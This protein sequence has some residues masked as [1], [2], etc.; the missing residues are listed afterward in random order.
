MA[1][2]DDKVAIIT[3]SAQG[4]GRQIALALARS[5]ADIVI[6]DLTK[7]RGEPV[8][9]EIDQIGAQV[10]TLGCDVTNE[11]H[12]ANLVKDSFNYFGHIDIL[13]NNAGWQYVNTIE[14]STLDQWKKTMAV[15]LRGP[16]LCCREV[17]PI[18]RKQGKGVIIN[19]TSRA[20]R[21]PKANATAYGASKFGLNGFTLCLNL[22]VKDFGIRVVALAPP[23]TNTPLARKIVRDLH[24]DLD[25]SSWPDGSEF[26]KIVAWFASDE[27][28]EIDG[29]II[30]TGGLRP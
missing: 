30:E 20:G 24:P 5:G 19:I 6:V 25:T 16:F 28:K 10:L 15:N 3:G 23:R 7:E 27:A 1:R 11:K 8:A 26:A 29:V 9:K 4:I 18:M 13:V 22:E 21:V 12:V 17:I 2:L 14:T